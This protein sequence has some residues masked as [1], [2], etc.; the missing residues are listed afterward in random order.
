MKFGTGKSSA[1]LLHPGSGIKQKGQ[2]LLH[3][4]TFCLPVEADEHLQFFRFDIGQGGIIEPRHLRLV[5]GV[6]LLL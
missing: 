4:F 2:C 5:H 6:H 1:V 3:R